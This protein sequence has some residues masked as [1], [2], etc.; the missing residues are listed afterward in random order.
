MILIL[1]ANFFVMII[2]LMKWNQLSF[3]SLASLRFSINN[4]V[5]SI[6]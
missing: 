5:K 1:A 4:L 2:D 3:D 6:E